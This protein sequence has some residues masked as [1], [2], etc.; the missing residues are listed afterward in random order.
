MTTLDESVMAAVKAKLPEMQAVA[1]AEYIKEAEAAKK[2]LAEVEPV[3]NRLVAQEKAL[4]E[5]DAIRNRAKQNLRTL[6]A[7]TTD[8]EAQ[9]QLNELSK[10]CAEEKVALVRELF[11]LVFRNTE[12]RKQVLA[13]K[14]V[15]VSN[16]R[17]TE[18]LPETTETRD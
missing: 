18:S 2:H 6:E 11:G 9:K 4:N 8:L 14:Q 7:K 13:N 5:A 12:V 1:L 15:S 10:K 16:D 3:L 17:Y